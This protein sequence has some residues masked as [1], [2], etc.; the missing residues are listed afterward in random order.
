VQFSKLPRVT[1]ECYGHPLM[2]LTDE[3]VDQE[4]WP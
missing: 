4:N 2:R 1:S 3:N